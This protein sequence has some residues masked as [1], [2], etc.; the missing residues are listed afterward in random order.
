MKLL[1]KAKN[2]LSIVLMLCVLA[3]MAPTALAAS[4]FKAVVSAKTM[5]VYSA[6]GNH[7]YLGSLKKGTVV[8]V[9]DY[10]KGIAKI[11][12]NGNIGLAYAKCMQRVEEKTNT[13]TEP[14]KPVPAVATQ[15]IR[16]YSK[17]STSSKYVTV[18]KGTEMNIIAV[19]GSVAM[20]EKNGNIGY[21]FKQ[22]L[23]DPA[24]Y[25]EE[26]EKEETSSAV[27]G[28]NIAVVTSQN[29]RIYKKASTSSA[30]VSVPKGLE[31]QLTA[32]SGDCAKVE[33]NGVVGYAYKSH[34]IRKS[35]VSVEE[36]SGSIQEESA[37]TNKK[38]DT[39][40]AKPEVPT[41]SSNPIF[42]SGKSNEEIT[43]LFLTKVMGYNTAAALGV[44]SNIKHES[45]YK[46]VSNGD[47]G[48]SYGICQW[49]AGRKTRLINWCNDNGY[50]HATLEGQLYYLKHDLTTSYTKVHKYLSTVENTAEGAYDAGYYFCYH[51]EGPSNKASK[52]IDRGEY[53]R[54]TLWNRY[55]K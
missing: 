27:T 32:I 30:Y 45:G 25:K 8:T 22:Y 10:A 48:S 7:K 52:S 23:V 42:N 29:T 49:H 3:G 14:V 40:A 9:T 16:I 54:D 46:P 2:A 21:T 34:L 33:L 38:E 36:N 39:P 37:N 12:Y 31:M 35:D 13:E 43:Y 6:K 50:D 41:G 15:K 26:V 24:A 55:N 51:F 47:S 1:K 19:N 4:S 28:L 18:A 20:V 53:A 44:M 11:S 17:A 5:K